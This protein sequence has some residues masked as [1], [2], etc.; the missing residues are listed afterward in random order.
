[1]A[2]PKLVTTC[3]FS[4]RH[5]GTRTEQA[6]Q[7]FGRA[8][9]LQEVAGEQ[10]ILVDQADLQVA[11]VHALDAQDPAFLDVVELG[12]HARSGRDM[13]GDQLGAGAGLVLAGQV[14]GQVVTTMDCSTSGLM[15]CDRRSI[16]ASVASQERA[17]ASRPG[18]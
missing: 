2:S 17:S 13:G 3:F 12:H 11:V 6:G 14:D 7:R 10:Q 18:R 5:H 15:M 4:P 8:L 16:T 9:E 1:M